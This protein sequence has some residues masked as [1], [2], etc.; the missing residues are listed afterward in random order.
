[1]GR[2]NE[3][4][5]ITPLGGVD[6][7]GHCFLYESNDSALVVDC[8][9]GI[10]T[11]NNRSESA[12]RLHVLDDILQRRKR[13]IGVI[14]HGHLDHIGA[15]AELLKRKIPVYLSEW[16]RRFLERY[17]RK[18]PKGAEFTIVSE[19]ESIRYGDFQVSFISLQHSIPGAL[20][21][22][23]SLKKKN[24]LHLGDFKFNGMEDSI[25]EF[26]RT[27]KRIRQK[28]GRIDCLV[29]DV[30]NVEM[31]GYTPPEFQVIDSL[32]KII[33]KARGRV[34][35]SFFSSNLRRMEKILKIGRSQKKTVGISGYGM[36]S[37]YNLIERYLE[38]NFEIPPQDGQVILIGGSQGEEN[39]GLAKMIW[40]E[41]RLLSISSRDTVVFSS[42]CIPGNEERMRVSLKELHKRGVKIILH[43]G[44][45]EKLNLPFDEIKEEFV[46]V[47]GHGQRDD[48]LKAIEILKPEMIIPFHASPEKY[49][50]FEN[51][52][53]NG[54]KIKRLSY[55]KTFKI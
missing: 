47:S 11:Y 55:L 16:S 8:G 13:V 4:I 21:I 48:I 3:E 18:I 5:S 50:I 43:Q 45:K 23:I 31:E 42:R 39:S 12:C 19:N 2:K 28:V 26:E 22:L 46:H 20:G 54:R 53:G 25:G 40:G 41:H 32:K 37:S 51:L 38:G 29:L 44:E 9:G 17:A 49:S 6:G 33:K 27:L 14:T 15:V 7:G 10:Q 24:I 34:I 52:I 35:I 36:R 1:M 30:L